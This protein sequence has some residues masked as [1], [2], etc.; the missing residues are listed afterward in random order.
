[1][2]IWPIKVEIYTKKIALQVLF[3]IFLEMMTSRNMFLIILVDSVH[4]KYL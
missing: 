1:M 4:L 2:F 3:D